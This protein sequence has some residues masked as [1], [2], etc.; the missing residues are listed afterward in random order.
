MQI[1]A[2]PESSIIKNAI[3]GGEINII[4]MFLLFFGWRVLGEF[5]ANSGEKSIKRQYKALTKTDVSLTFD[6]T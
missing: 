3:I 4:L 6:K 5:E 1:V 2:S